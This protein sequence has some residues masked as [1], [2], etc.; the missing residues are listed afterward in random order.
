MGNLDRR[1]TR[2]TPEEVCGSGVGCCRPCIRSQVV[3]LEPRCWKSMVDEQR[4]RRRRPLRVGD[5]PDADESS[6]PQV[7]RPLTE[8]PARSYRLADLKK[9]FALSYNQCALSGCDER[10][11]DPAWPAVL[12][13][14]CHIYGLKPGS[15][16]HL[17]GMSAADAN[18][19]ENLVLLCRNCH[20]KVDRLFVD[21]YP[22][23]RLLEIKAAHESRQ[24]AKPWCA[25]E[26][27][28]E[29]SRLLAEA[30]G[31]DIPP[32]VSGRVTGLVKWWSDEKGYGFIA[33]DGGGDDVFVHFE[34]DRRSRIPHT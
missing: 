31:L 3:E 19:Y 8:S 32:E 12:A 26:R 30:L 9:L 23:D 29:L 4:P 28:E 6:P 5:Q 34:R 10:L 16:R 22:A 21:H 33:P 13:E 15:A 17:P 27:L 1:P 25:P 7:P 14:I 24:G 11:S 18:A 20:L 2:R